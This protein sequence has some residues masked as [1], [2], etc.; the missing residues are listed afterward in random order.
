MSSR[1]TT[2]TLGKL[3]NGCSENGDQVSDCSV[4]YFG[5]IRWWKTGSHFAIVNRVKLAN[6]CNLFV[7]IHGLMA[8]NRWKY[9][10]CCHLSQICC[11]LQ[12]HKLTW[13]AEDHRLETGTQK[14][15]Q[16]MSRS[17]WCR[18]SAVLLLCKN[19]SRTQ[20]PFEPSSL[21]QICQVV[22]ICADWLQ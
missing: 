7:I 16:Q 21:L 12:A 1:H 9:Q 20:Q 18:G 15:L 5:G 2:V 8:I 22:L 19:I 10:I 4:S 13:T 6:M 14:F 3:W 11:R 17:S